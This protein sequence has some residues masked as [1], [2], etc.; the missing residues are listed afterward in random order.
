MENFFGRLK[1]EM[2]YGEKFQK[3]EVFVH[4]MKKY[5]TLPEQCEKFSQAKRNESDTIPNSFANNFIIIL[6][7]S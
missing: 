7:N 3:V 4:F 2:Y 1:L 5:I 6:F